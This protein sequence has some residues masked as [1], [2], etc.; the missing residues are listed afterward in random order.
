VMATRQRR[1]YD[2]TTTRRD[3]DEMTTRRRDDDEM[4]TRRC[5]HTEEA[6]GGTWMDLIED[7]GELRT[8]NTVGGAETTR[9]QCE[10][11]TSNNVGCNT[12][13]LCLLYHISRP[14]H[15]GCQNRAYACSPMM[16]G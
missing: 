6:T 15:V 11:V 3:D 1:D 5:R 13:S 9:F 16:W 10:Y 4:T 8:D 14:R 7:P 12:F 2:E